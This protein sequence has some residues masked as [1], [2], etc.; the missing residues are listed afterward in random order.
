MSF[1]TKQCIMLKKVSIGKKNS[2]Y[3]SQVKSKKLQ[4]LLQGLKSSWKFLVS[5][6]ELYLSTVLEWMCL[7]AVYQGSSRPN[8][9]A[10]WHM[11]QW[12][13]G[14]LTSFTWVLGWCM[15]QLW[16]FNRLYDNIWENEVSRWSQPDLAFH[17]VSC[18]ILIKRQCQRSGQE[19]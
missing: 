18:N 4:C 5:T 1:S 6:S 13:L 19:Q 2:N 9:W 16:N 11:S 14:P 8:N 3:P 7:L 17:I 10:T 15:A 12:T